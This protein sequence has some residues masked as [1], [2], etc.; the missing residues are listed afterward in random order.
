MSPQPHRPH[1]AAEPKP[2]ILV[3]LERLARETAGGGGRHGHASMCIGVGQG[4]ALIL[5]RA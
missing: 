4:I 1:H 3:F 2:D 5:E